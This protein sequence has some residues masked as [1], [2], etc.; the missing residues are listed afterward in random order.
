MRS[1]A[2]GDNRHGV[3]VTVVLLTVISIVGSLLFVVMHNGAWVFDDNFFLVISSQEG[4]TWHWLTS[5]SFEHWD[6]AY[7][8]LISLQRQLFYFDY[9]WALVVMLLLLGSSMFVLERTLALLVSNRWASIGLAAWF[10]LSLVWARPLQWWSAG[11]QYFPYTLFDLV[12]LYGFVR[13]QINKDAKWGWVSVAALA[14]ALLF[15]EKPAYMPLYLLL[16]Q[17]LLFS[18]KTSARS[19]AT[20]LWRGRW[21]W[22][23]YVM[24]VGAWAAGYIHANAYS[25]HP[26]ITLHQYASYFRILWLQTLAPTLLGVTIP[27]TNLNA[28][29]ISVV[30]IAQLLIIGAIVASVLRRRNAWRAWVFMAAVVIATGLLVASARVHQFG[31]AIA[32]DPRYLIDFAWLFPLGLCAAFANGDRFS[33]Q[34]P[35]NTRLTLPGRFTAMSAA[36]GGILCISCGAAIASTITVEHKWPGQNARRWENNVRN[37]FAALWRNGQHPVVAGGTVPFEIISEWVAPY[38]RLARVLPLYVGP[39]QVNGPLTGPLVSV[40]GAGQIHRAQID[41]VTSNVSANDL[42]RE[43][44]IQVGPG[45]R[46]VTNRR[47]LC[48][49]SGGASVGIMRTISPPREASAKAY[50]AVAYYRA[51][52]SMVLPVNVV[53]VGQTNKSTGYELSV[54]SKSRSSI[55]WIGGVVPQ[56]IS[57][58]IPEMST[59]CLSRLGVAIVHVAPPS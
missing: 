21:L 8:A 44:T 46:V 49:I 40:D 16:A 26:A 54:S 38:N 22:I 56:S 13:F 59:L 31:V 3:P 30:I 47:E 53:G 24:V 33:P 51:W 14:S 12:C 39:V 37:G 29:Q 36:M 10:G 45:G 11:L 17:G 42:F 28:A 1:R 48:V 27:A 5:V 57:L 20:D 23:G 34:I 15:Y 4:F 35:S 25:A 6:L 55:T 43:H 58:S 52:R 18:G 32:N 7:H 19:L 41:P 9:R 50:Y 2:L